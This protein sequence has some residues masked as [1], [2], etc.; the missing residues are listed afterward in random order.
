[1]AQLRNSPDADDQASL[2]S[3]AVTGWLQNLRVEELFVTCLSCRHLGEK[4][5]SCKRYPGYPIPAHT[6]LTGCKEYSD[7][8]PKRQRDAKGRIIYEDEDIPF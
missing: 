8:N 3:A 7:N 1:M 2:L 5:A 6:V 4:G